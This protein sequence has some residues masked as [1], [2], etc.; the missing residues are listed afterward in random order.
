MNFHLK[1]RLGVD[2]VAIL[3]TWWRH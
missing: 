3:V 1:D 2:F